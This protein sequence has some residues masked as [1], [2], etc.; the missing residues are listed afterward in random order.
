MN[1]SIK[2]ELDIIQVDFHVKFLVGTSNGSV[3]RV[4]THTTTGL[5]L[6]PRPL[7]REVKRMACIH[8]HRAA[9]ATEAPLQVDGC[10]SQTVSAN[11]LQYS[12][13]TH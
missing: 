3:V 5:F 12:V 2:L 1:L 13:F 10:K 6:L 9:V 8:E 11:M 4:H 7:M